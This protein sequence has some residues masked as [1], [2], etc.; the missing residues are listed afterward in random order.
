MKTK[1]KVF[2]YHNCFPFSHLL[3]KAKPVMEINPGLLFSL[4]PS[5]SQE[6]L[7][8]VSH[9]EV[10]MEVTGQQ[11]GREQRAQ[12]LHAGDQLHKRVC[13]LQQLSFKVTGLI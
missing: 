6:S 9:K 11:H 13:V 8:L 4:S 2:L 10:C 3:F 7:I 12:L 5:L 1:L